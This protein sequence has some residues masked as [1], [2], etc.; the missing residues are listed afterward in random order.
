MDGVDVVVSAPA[1]FRAADGKVLWENKDAKHLSSGGGTF[2]DKVLC[3]PI[4][5]GGIGFH[6]YDFT[7]ARGE[8]L[9]PVKRAGDASAPEQTRS[10]GT[11]Y[12]PKGT[13]L[14]IFFFG[15]QRPV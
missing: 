1:I 7:D 10:K 8:M 5:C 4:A 6:V 9:E 11:D 2:A 3:L 12:E 14:D 15:A 13:W